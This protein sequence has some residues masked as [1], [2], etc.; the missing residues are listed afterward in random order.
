MN[1]GKSDNIMQFSTQSNTRGGKVIVDS[2]DSE[3]NEEQS[4]NEN[5][6][7]VKID[8]GNP[9]SNQKGKKL[10]VI[11]FNDVEN[12]TKEEKHTMPKAQ[13]TSPTEES[14]V[15]SIKHTSSINSI[16]RPHNTKYYMADDA[17]D[18]YENQ[19]YGYHQRSKYGE[20]SG[21]RSHSS[22]RNQFY[23]NTEDNY[24]NGGN[25]YDR[26]EDDLYHQP[27]KFAFGQRQQVSQP[28]QQPQ[29][30]PQPQPQQQQPAKSFYKMQPPPRSQPSMNSQYRE[31][32]QTR[33]FFGGRE[34]P[35]PTKQQ[36]QPQQQ[37]P[38]QQEFRPRQHEFRPQQRQQDFRPNQQQQKTIN[39][40]FNQQKQPQPNVHT[41]Q[42][43]EI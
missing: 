28:Q 38:Q 42:P 30:Q 5:L 23:D 10:P 33:S 40:N 41:F 39:I 19:N 22:R 26:N 9:N 7:I 34:Q 24:D 17:D 29:P 1:K 20:Y 31:T 15:N 37:Q 16:H 35:D 2:S 25:Y 13:E 11:S 14:Q 8:W 36:P 3:D 27:T 21:H 32:Q 18:I 4:E 12:Q 43:Q 6:N